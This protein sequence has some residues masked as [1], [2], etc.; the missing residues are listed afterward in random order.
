MNKK[1]KVVMCPV[2]RAPYITNVS[3]SLQNLQQIVGGYIEALR[4]S[5]DCV[6]VCNEEGR[7]RGLPDNPSVSWLMPYSIQGDVFFCG[8]AGEE[9]TDIPEDC[10]EMILRACKKM[11]LQEGKQ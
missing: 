4:I 8:V 6:M 10:R 9:F 2:D 3:D 11:W 5:T 7:I 1:M